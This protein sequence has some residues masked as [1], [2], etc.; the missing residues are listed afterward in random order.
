MTN[1]NIPGLSQMVSTYQMSVFLTQNILLTLI[2]TLFTIVLGFVPGSLGM[3]VKFNHDGYDC[4][5][6]CSLCICI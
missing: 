5:L 4:V 2:M 6:L 3:V 1:Q